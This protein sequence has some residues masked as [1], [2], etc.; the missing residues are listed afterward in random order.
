MATKAKISK[1]ND[2]YL[3]ENESIWKSLD[4]K[5]WIV[6]EFTF[7]I[8]LFTF[9]VFAIGTRYPYMMHENDGL[10]P[11][12]TSRNIEANYDSLRYDINNLCNDLMNCSINV[13]EQYQG[14]D[15]D[16]IYNVSNGSGVL[17][18]DNVSIDTESINEFA[19]LDNG[20]I[21]TFTAADNNIIAYYDKSGSLI[22]KITTTLSSM[23]NLSNNTGVYATCNGSRR[24]VIKYTI[25]S[26]GSFEETLVGSFDDISCE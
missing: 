21:A 12:D 6:A 24:D 4:N 5:T 1:K 15:I 25:L 17:S 22:K 23:G 9:T 19:L 16:I 26:D 18:I 7:Y 3:E 20:Y 13:S 2:V 8:V 14:E 10:A 11:G